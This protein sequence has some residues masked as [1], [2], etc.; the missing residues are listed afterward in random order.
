[1]GADERVIEIDGLRGIAVSLVLIWH[2]FGALLPKHASPVVGVL[3]ETLIFGRTGVD[4]FFVLSGFLIVGILVDRRDCTNYFGIFY[5]RRSLR[6]LPPYLLLIGIFWAITLQV[7]PSQ[8]FNKDIPLWSYLTF[9]QNLN[10]AAMNAW[11]PSGASVTW[12][13]A[14]EEQFYLACPLIVYMTPFRYLARV[15]LGVGL[16]SILARG[17]SYLLVP[18]NVFAPYVFTLFRL[19]G[20]C[21]GG[22]IALAYR[23]QETF[24]A[25]MLRRR[26]LLRLLI[27]YA[28]TIPAFLYAL[29][30]SL[31]ATMYFW[32]HTYLTAFYSL[33]LLN[34]LTNIGSSQLALLRGTPLR[35]VGRISYGLY[36][37]HPL[38]IALIFMVFRKSEKLATPFDALLL[39]V[40]LVLS[41]A[42]CAASYNLVERRCLALGRRLRYSPV[43]AD[44][45]PTIEVVETTAGKP[46][47]VASR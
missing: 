14:I 19:D 24:A 8:Y 5:A 10:M 12:S 23:D 2:F 38:F 31:P 11:G 40:A 20:L 1:L 4:L 6:I 44:T 39:A 3:A 43:D 47:A 15:L 26:L 29:K 42:F 35:A 9:T 41:F 18:E 45:R 17:M 37:F 27:V 21:A 33:V 36:L 46:P 22:L 34:V 28:A 7:S 13:V 30:L 32:G 16:A 25:L